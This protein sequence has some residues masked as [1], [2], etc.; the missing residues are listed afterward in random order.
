M[1]PSPRPEAQPGTD[2]D[3]WDKALEQGGCTKENQT[4]LDC[5]MKH[6]DWRQCTKEMMAFKR[7]WDERKER[8]Q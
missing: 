7:C 1:S 8:T 6:G 2:A 5:K 4:L 3:N